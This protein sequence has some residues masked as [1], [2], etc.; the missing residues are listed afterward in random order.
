MKTGPASA[1]AY[2]RSQAGVTAKLPSLLPVLLVQSALPGYWTSP[3]ATHDTPSQQYELLSASD[4]RLTPQT[5]R[6]TMEA[7]HSN[8][9]TSDP[10]AP[11]TGRFDHANP[12]A[13]LQ[14]FTN[15]KNENAFHVRAPSKR[16]K[17]KSRPK[18][19]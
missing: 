13:P 8:S 16:R 15:I 11:T 10:E 12:F 4:D 1:G 2:T 5:A 17:T 18:G 19:V 6:E 3:S 9:N 7:E 14:S